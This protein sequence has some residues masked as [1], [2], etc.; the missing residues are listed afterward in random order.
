ML[1]IAS[2][3]ARDNS[4]Q[5]IKIEERETRNTDSKIEVE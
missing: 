1:S 3:V 2:A 4:K 5:K